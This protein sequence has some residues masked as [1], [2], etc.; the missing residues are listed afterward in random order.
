VREALANARFR[1]ELPG[2]LWVLAHLGGRLRRNS[3]RIVPGDDVTVEVSPYD[4]RMGRIVYR[5]RRP[6]T[7]ETT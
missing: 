4:P 1:V 2:G 5:G 7:A 6:A 3:I